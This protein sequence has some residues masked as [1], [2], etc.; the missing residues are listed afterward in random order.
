MMIHIGVWP[1]FVMFVC[2]VVVPAVMALGVW[3]LHRH[4]LKSL[5]WAQ[6]GF[7][8]LFLVG[9]WLLSQNSVQLKGDALTLQAGV[10]KTSVPALS[11]SHNK[12]AV[13]GFTELGDF[14]PK[15]AVD[16]IRLPSYQVGWFRLSNDDV[17]FVMLIGEVA[18]V[19]IVRSPQHTVIVGADLSTFASL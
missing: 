15:D 19:S 12:V 10:Y 13:V 5:L 16:G 18:K 3:W 1:V 6:L 11:A 9:C 4:H 2:F 8:S 14:T 7:T 17:A